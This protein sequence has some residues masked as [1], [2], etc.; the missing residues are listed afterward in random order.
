[1]HYY[2]YY[3]NNARAEGAVRMEKQSRALYGGNE[4]LFFSSFIGQCAAC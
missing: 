2:Y 1:M 3:S 4:S